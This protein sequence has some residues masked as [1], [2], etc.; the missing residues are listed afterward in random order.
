MTKKNLLHVWGDLRCKSR[1]E[2]TYMVDIL[3]LISQYV[4]TSSGILLQNKPRLYSPVFFLQFTKKQHFTPGVY[5][6]RRLV[7][8]ATKFCTVRANI[9]GVIAALLALCAIMPIS[10]HAQGRTRQETVR[11]SQSLPYCGS[12]GW[13]LLHVTLLTP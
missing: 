3:R 1:F 13:V 6:S 9:L 5:E 2:P 4:P 12:S 10:A 8:R 11:F 7:T